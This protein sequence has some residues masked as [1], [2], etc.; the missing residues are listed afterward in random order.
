MQGFAY[1]SQG[2]TTIT[3]SGASL[4]SSANRSI[5]LS[6]GS[7]DFNL[8]GNPYA[9][10]I[11]WTND[12]HWARENIKSDIWINC[13]DEPNDASFATYNST[14]GVCT[15][16]DDN[17]G[18]GAGI[19]PPTQAFWVEVIAEPCTLQVM[20]QAQ[21]HTTN[22]VNKKSAT[23]NPLIRLQA[24][25][26]GYTDE[27]VIFF[28][29]NAA[30]SIDKYDTRKK[31]GSGAYPQLYAPVTDGILAV[32][33]LPIPSAGKQIVV[34]V[35]LQS[36]VAGSITLSLTELKSLAEGSEVH[37]VDRLLDRT[38][39]LMA[40]PS[41]TIELEG[42][43]EVP[44]RLEVVITMGGQPGDEPIGGV[45]LID[46]QTQPEITIYAHRKS[47]YVGNIEGRTHLEVVNAMGQRVLS[48]KLEAQGLNAI[49]T[50]LPAGIY[51]VSVRSQGG[52]EVKRVFLE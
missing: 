48:R 47:I 10:A 3:F 45:N 9:S 1:A 39:N 27:M 12:D 41:Y 37:L 49:H 13:A 52:R 7:T 5:I 50:N 46:A 23:S 19:I 42:V 25:R 28:H 21:T 29:P 38:V 15:N 16:W 11:D 36:T 43:G 22:V 32:N 35:T 33:S 31:L 24:L 44:D 8:V 51:I 6:S 26:A 20:R 17:V 14:S 40:E 2:A 18:T 34:P 4:Y 30:A